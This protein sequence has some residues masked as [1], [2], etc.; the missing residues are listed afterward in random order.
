MGVGISF[1]RKIRRAS[2]EISRDREPDLML[3]F[4]LMLELSSACSTVSAVLSLF[5]SSLVLSFDLI[6]KSLFTDQEGL[7]EGDGDL[8]DLLCLSDFAGAVPTRT[9]GDEGTGGAGLGE[10]YLSCGFIVM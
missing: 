5:E 7:S 2:G 9:C 3:E 10:M 4:D 1:E 6:L 8:E